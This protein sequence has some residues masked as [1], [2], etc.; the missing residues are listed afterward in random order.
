MH[1]KPVSGEKQDPIQEMQNRF[2][3]DGRGAF[4]IA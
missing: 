4:E 3:S 1:R 2:R